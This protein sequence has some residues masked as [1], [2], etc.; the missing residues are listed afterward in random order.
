M[1]L[2]SCKDVSSQPMESQSQGYYSYTQPQ[3]LCENT[4]HGINDESR[5]QQLEDVIRAHTSFINKST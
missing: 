3:L 1:N 2:N 4:P 5:D